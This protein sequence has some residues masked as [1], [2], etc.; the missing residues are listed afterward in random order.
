[1]LSYE[2]VDD[3]SQINLDSSWVPVAKFNSKDKFFDEKGS[4]VSS[5]Y[6]GRKYRIVEKREKN[7]PIYERVFKVFIGSL[8]II[9][10]FGLALHLKS[11]RKLFESKESILFG[12]LDRSIY[13]RQNTPL[14][15]DLVQDKL[16][17]WEEGLRDSVPAPSVPRVSLSDLQDHRLI[18]IQELPS[19]FEHHLELNKQI[20]IKKE[21]STD[22][23]T[24]LAN[25]PDNQ[26]T[27]FALYRGKDLAGCGQ[28]SFGKVKLAQDL[29]TGKWC[30][31]K[32]AKVPALKH[33]PF[34]MQTPD[35]E[36]RAL[37]ALGMLK[38]EA[39]RFDEKNQMHVFYIFMKHVNG[40]SLLYKKVD[41]KAFMEIAMSL[42]HSLDTLHQKG[43]LHR[44]ISLK[45]MLYDPNP[46]TPLLEKAHL[47]DFGS[48]LPVDA[49]G[50]VIVDDHI[51]MTY[52]L[53][54]WGDSEG[55]IHLSQYTD[56]FVMVE[57]LRTLYQ[58]IEDSRSEIEL[59]G[60]K[61]DKHFWSKVS[62]LLKE[63]S[64]EFSI[65]ALHAATLT[66]SEAYTKFE[67]LYTSVDWT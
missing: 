15:K 21:S 46:S 27:M 14:S 13:P 9:F 51:G 54:Q 39:Y 25:T 8:A 42:F 63:I 12:I 41:M 7:L 23:S 1:M 10:S 40:E 6:T 16:K 44:D 45:N 4:Q 3:I 28:G 5:D 58:D 30:A 43:F 22:F 20:K 18:P 19:R 57:E 55:N 33:N 64:E 38:G 61:V 60:N 31:V 65:N 29:Q 11:V 59:E 17:K 52:C 67:E 48:A 35:N 37:K 36:K 47:V 34:K 2:V 32:I 49:K 50:E 26:Q 56:M 66:A 24:I 53:I 62:S